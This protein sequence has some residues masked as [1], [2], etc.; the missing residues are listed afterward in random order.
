M[1]EFTSN[2]FCKDITTTIAAGLGIRILGE[3]TLVLKRLET[4]LQGISTINFGK[5]ENTK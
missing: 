1:V 3:D 4:R 5:G 2:I